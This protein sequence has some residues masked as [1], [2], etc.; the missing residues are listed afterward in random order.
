[1]IVHEPG[2][3]SV[4]SSDPCALVFEC[5]GWTGAVHVGAGVS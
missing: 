5:G 2:E 3:E 1:V 4:E